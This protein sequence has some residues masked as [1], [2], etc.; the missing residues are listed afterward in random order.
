MP[1]DTLEARE[2]RLTA[3]EARF[4]PKLRAALIRSIEPAVSAYE[5]GATPVLAAAFVKETDV[6]TVLEQLYRTVAVAEATR[7]YDELTEGQK[8]APPVTAR[9]GWLARA[10]RFIREE[11]RVALNGLTQRTRELVQEVL[12]EAQTLGLSVQDAAKRLRE[13]AATVSRERAT[14]IVR[15]ELNASSN[16]GSLIGAQATGLKLRKKWLDTKDGRARP[17]HVAANGQ[18]VALDGFFTVGAGQGRYPGDPLLPVG[19]RARCRCTQ[20]YVPIE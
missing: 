5:Q 1:T 3:Y 17:T 18:T 6:A 20:T 11:G 4:S 14:A 8:A 9:E 7:T 16:F 2:Q 12:V 19:E 10:R 13:Q 15:T